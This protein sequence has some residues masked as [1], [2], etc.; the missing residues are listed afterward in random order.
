MNNTVG[1]VGRDWVFQAI[2][3]W[4]A[5]AD[6][7]R[8]MILTGEP[9][10]GKTAIAEELRRRMAAPLSA[11]VRSTIQD[12]LR[13]VH[14]CTARKSS[15][16]DA[17]GFVRSISLQLA[18][19]VPAFYQALAATQEPYVRIDVTQTVG[20]A[21]QV[22]AIADLHLSGPSA[23][24]SFV[25]ALIHPLLHMAT[26]PDR[27]VSLALLVDGLDESFSTDEPT[28]TDLLGSAEE[29]PGWVRIIAT[30]RPLERV[31]L[32]LRHHRTIDLSSEQS[33]ALNRTDLSSYVSAALSEIPTV[34]SNGTSAQQL[35]AAIERN[36]AGN[37]LY[38]KLLLDDV[39]A[40]RLDQQSIDRLPS[41]LHGYFHA[42][43]TR[44]AGSSWNDSSQ[45]WSVLVAAREPL[46]RQHAERVAQIDSAEFRKFVARF[47]PFLER[48]QSEGAQPTFSLFHQSLRDFLA[49]DQLTVADRSIDNPHHLDP[50][51]GHCIFSAFYGG[52]VDVAATID[53][54]AV[55]DY[56]L[57]HLPLH[58]MAGGFAERIEPLLMSQFLRAKIERFHDYRS[59]RQDLLRGVQAAEATAN[60]AAMLR[61]SLTVDSF[62]A[63]IGADIPRQFAP[64]YAV[65][66]QVERA[67]DLAELASAQWVR[68]VAL[69]SIVAAIA[70][71]DPEKALWVANRQTSSD[72]RAESLV[73][74]LK[75][76]LVRDGGLH[77][78]LDLL[79]T[80][81]ANVET[82]STF[83]HRSLIYREL[84]ATLLPVAPPQAQEMFENAARTAR[85]EPDAQQRALAF[86]HLSQAGESQPQA[87]RIGLL[88]ESLQALLAMHE[89]DWRAKKFGTVVSD[90][91]SFDVNEALANARAARD[92]HCRCYGLLSASVHLAAINQDTA[93]EVLAEAEQDIYLIGIAKAEGYGWKAAVARAAKTAAKEI[94]LIAGGQKPAPARTQ[95]ETVIKL[96][97]PRASTDGENAIRQIESKIREAATPNPDDLW[98]KTLQAKLLAAVAEES[99]D[100][101]LELAESLPAGRAEAME[102]V[103]EAF[104]RV[105]LNRALQL[106]GTSAPDNEWGKINVL[107][108]LLLQATAHEH[109][110]LTEILI[111]LVDE[112]R[113]TDHV[114]PPD[115]DSIHGVFQWLAETRPILSGSDVLCNTF[116]AAGAIVARRSPELARVFLGF[117]LDQLQGDHRC[118]GRAIADIAKFNPHLAWETAA[119]AR[120]A[121]EVVEY[122]GEWFRNEGLREV[123]VAI[124]P[125]AS[126]FALDTIEHSMSHA[127]CRAVGYS[128][129]ARAYSSQDRALADLFLA[130]ARHF[131]LSSESDWRKVDALLRMA[132]DCAQWNRA[133]VDELLDSALSI[134]R[135]PT[136]GQ[137]QLARS[138]ANAAELL[139]T[140]DGD[141]RRARELLE[142]SCDRVREPDTSSTEIEAI[143]AAALLDSPEQALKTAA[144]L[145]QALAER[146]ASMDG[147]PLHDHVTEIAPLLIHAHAQRAQTAETLLQNIAIADDLSARIFIG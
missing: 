13:A 125:Y 78:S 113:A 142:K 65:A 94:A 100:R 1:F 18:N 140:L 135:A 49:L 71:K 98:R 77:D 24:R 106:L 5:S 29:L 74:L 33:A 102:V 131:A 15:S 7:P 61:F 39:A 16:I 144:K 68:A 133:A 38:C 40:G 69:R 36:A 32:S 64:L 55:D 86:W 111:T 46:T 60:S 134:A 112:C 146:D 139:F 143:V 84:F 3:Q 14:F 10:S 137:V 101:A 81:V 138:Y 109:P 48:T 124:A 17:I 62:R 96:M 128:A 88:V 9:G 54:A 63:R 104:G 28:I 25:V 43:L 66:G 58:L 136:E 37:F 108:E 44:A 147:S 67:V 73:L 42:A 121:Y 26:S 132:A 34:A 129:L 89:G 41:G 97:T 99:P 8:F 80:L 95:F 35:A 116:A 107:A 12:A 114:R 22:T 45:V 79:Q 20:T 123:A 130:K 76:H 4:L 31:F 105:D 2:E 50:R 117:V 27:P 91:A 93:H 141:K 53:W 70:V 145:L 126:E 51:L 11:N 122:R 47:E 75:G 85:E 118:V 30:T 103:I 19:A 87:I 120:R 72:A 82:M 52:I 23:R 90:L 6:G 59:I 119:N 127:D 115:A 92:P 21:Q 56:G 83:A 110:Q 57:R